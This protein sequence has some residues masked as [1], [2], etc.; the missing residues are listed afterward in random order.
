M[1]R[2]KNNPIKKVLVL[3]I[4]F[5]MIL[6]TVVKFDIYALSI[7]DGEYTLPVK[8]LKEYDDETSMGNNALMQEAKLSVKNGKAELRIKF[9]PLK[10]MGY[11][12][13][14]GNLEVDS[15]KVKVE[16]YYDKLDTYNHPTK[17]TDKFMKGKKYPKDISFPINI[18]TRELKV[19]VY[20]P[21]MGELA[22]GNQKARLKIEWPE[23]LSSGKSS[24]K[25]VDT[26]KENTNREEVKK[27][28]DNNIQNKIVKNDLGYVISND[29]IDR[30][31]KLPELPKGEELKL[32]DG[33][34]RVDVEL[35]NEREDK[36]S[37]GNNALVHEAYIHSEKNR[38]RMYIGSKSMTVSNI[39]A[40]L[41]SLQILDGKN[42]Y[43]S[44]PYAYDLEIKGE[45]EKRPEVFE[46][47]IK[48]KSPMMY[49]KVDPKVKPM[50]EVPIGAR[51]KIKWDTLKK[52]EKEN[53]DLYK[54][55]ESGTKRPKFDKNKDYKK[56][57]DNNVYL[58]SSPNTFDD[59]PRFK[60]DEIFG[61]KQYLDAVNKVGRNSKTYMFNI[62]VENE[63]NMPIK[64]N[65]SFVLKMDN[66]L[67]T[68]NLKA[69]Y[70]DNNDP[71]SIKNTNDGIELM[72][73]RF[74]PV[75]IYTQ[76]KN[77]IGKKN[78]SI[79]GLN[80]NNH[81]LSR[82]KNTESKLIFKSM[83]NSGTN[84][85]QSKK[86]GDASTTSSISKSNIE[87]SST[88]A[89]DK[90]SIIQSSNFD[91]HEDI[92]KE[93]EVDNSSD[94]EKNKV[95]KIENIKLIFV[96][97]AMGVLLLVISGYCY[98]TVGKKLIYEI[99]Y[100]RKLDEIIKQNT[101]YRK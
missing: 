35:Y 19:K 95:K 71:I 86:S 55:K 20:V 14:L 66:R 31:S 33:F 57:I 45:D 29:D 30:I 63:Y 98:I 64:N 83:S 80:M 9:M 2:R 79:N 39:V 15:T 28:V 74:G 22:D 51:L 96:V 4:C 41:V 91:S 60:F 67:K 76:E 10:F 6:P 97:I 42:Y 78:T 72:M 12:G 65:R 99:K 49:V 24:S 17:G 40:S 52:T 46:F 73:K 53:I 26:K 90:P 44:I 27:I 37:M 94:K 87:D 84:I 3:L 68:K 77:V 47:D 101:E 85:T 11:E 88:T 36:L 69:M 58:L 16:S 7:D 70:I 23:K 75:C 38:N 25:T 34:Y 32:D 100:G 82:G 61:G 48:N 50:G 18:G 1:Y 56:K 62:S 43:F 59:Y 92:D 8:L 81:G 93:E 21:V 89:S 5:M 54:K 13:Y